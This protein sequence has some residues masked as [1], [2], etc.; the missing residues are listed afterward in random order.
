MSI[1]SSVLPIHRRGCFTRSLACLEALLTLSCLYRRKACALVS[2]V[3][4][5]G[6]TAS[7]NLSGIKWQILSY[8]SRRLTSAT[9]SPYSRASESR[10]QFKCLF[11]V[12][13]GAPEA[14]ILF[15]LPSVGKSSTTVIA[16]GAAQYQR[17]PVLVRTTPYLHNA[18]VLALEQKLVVRGDD[19]YAPE[20]LLEAILVAQDVAAADLIRFVGYRALLDDLLRLLHRLHV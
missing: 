3:V 4:G 15:T 9:P 8:M 2:V 17:I 5:T 18:W 10:R 11:S 19:W 20:E 14:D 7:L 1:G 16:D 6:Q 13:N 12:G